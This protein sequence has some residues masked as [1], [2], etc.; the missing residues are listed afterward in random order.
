MMIAVNKENTS[1]KPVYVMVVDD[2]PVI[3]GVF[4][5]VLDSDPD[6]KVVAR[7][8]NG[9][10]AINILKRTGEN[11]VTVDVMTL[12]I[13]MPIMD[14]LTALPEIIRLVP[15]INVIMV[16]TL[17]SD[18]ACESMKAL[19]LGATD[20][21][22]KPEGA[23][24]G[25]LMRDFS[26]ILLEKV[27]TLGRAAKA[28]SKTKGRGGAEQINLC[29]VDTDNIPEVLAIG[30]STGGP[31]A[32]NVFFRALST[33][34]IDMPIFITQHMPPKF[35]KI[36]AKQLTEISGMQCAEA[37]DGET[38]KAGRVYL[39]PGDFHMTVKRTGS[40][41][42]VHTDQNPQENFCRPAVDPMLRSIAEI[43]GKNTLILIMTGMGADGLAGCRE[44]VNQGGVVIAQD[45][46]T[47]VV[48]GMPGAIATN[49]LCAK[50][51]PLSDLTE[52]IT[53]FSMGKI[54]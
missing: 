13:Q 11:K 16:S 10:D 34:K 49:G 54:T 45:K 51:A 19:E 4:S 29:S 1:M 17:T 44:I 42:T 31:Q 40:E 24:N 38:V 37:I 18:G 46:E 32:L 35:T 7:A 27:K 41:I 12:D 25:V 39:A 23:F 43:Y 14:G 30:C 47:S 9:Q 50:V 5:A 8:K 3:N 48:W 53:E 22:N 6:I 33:K 21:M 36:L 2:S 15:N 52:V 20:Y 28:E 26:Q